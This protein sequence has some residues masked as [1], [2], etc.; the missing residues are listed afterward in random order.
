MNKKKVHIIVGITSIVLIVAIVAIFFL[1]RR[2]KSV[3]MDYTELYRTD[4]INS[5]SAKGIV[6]SQEK[7]NVY[8]TVTATIKTVNIKVGDKVSAG[9]LLCQLDTEDLRLNLAQQ[10]VEFTAAQQSGLKGQQDNQS[11]INS[12]KL[13]LDTK[14][15]DY[16]N[17]KVLYEAGDMSKSE[18]DQAKT[19][20]TQAQN[21]YQDALRAL[22]E[23]KEAAG[24]ELERKNID[25]Q[26]LEKQIQE[27]SIIAPISGTITAVYAREG[28]AGS[29]LLFIIEDT[30]RL[31]ITTKFREYDIGRVS[32]GIS[33]V[34]KTDYTGDSEYSGTIAEVDPTAVK[35]TNGDTLASTDV[36]FSAKVAVTSETSNLRIGAN[37][38]LSVIT[39]KKENVY[40]VSYD[41][42]ATA[43]NGET[44][45]YAAQ[46]KGGKY[47]AQ[48]ITVST[49]LETDFYVEIT[50]DELVDGMKILKE[51]SALQNSMTIKLG[52]EEQ[53]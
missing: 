10:N 28:A 7:R 19:A 21:K 18:L 14:T 37:A 1:I 9:D 34:I 8:S 47:L 32:P 4:L 5:I 29:G 50:G 39:D 35:N 24:K 13:D 2:D 15:T 17:T 25:I 43:E 49:G 53:I 51:A 46:E 52:Q 45:I 6:E 11:N 44:V 36:E 22:V 38:N 31:E 30:D 26:K 23:A 48:A 3:V 33:V 20:Y 12:T 16:N 42:L 40:C 27:A 41:A